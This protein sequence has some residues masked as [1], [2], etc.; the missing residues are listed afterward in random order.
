[1][2]FSVLEDCIE[3]GEQYRIDRPNGAIIVRAL[4]KRKPVANLRPKPGALV[5]GDELDTFSPSDWHPN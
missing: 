1:M 5:D 2:L 3:T 4:R